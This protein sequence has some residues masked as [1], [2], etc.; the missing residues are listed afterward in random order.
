M[1][2]S[3]T[4]TADPHHTPTFL[5]LRQHRA[6]DTEALNKLFLRHYEAVFRSL[7]VRLHGQPPGC[8]VEDL[9]QDAMLAAIE[10]LEQ[11]EPQQDAAWR[12]WVVTIGWRLFL[13]RVRDANTLKRGAGTRTEPLQTAS[14]S[15]RQL[16]GQASGE[17][18]AVIASE[19]K[20]LMDLC[21]SQ[22]TGSRRVVI[23]ERDYLGRDWPD[24]ARLLNREVGACQ[25]LHL[26][27]RTKLA[28]LMARARAGRTEPPDARAAETPST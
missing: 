14:G 7:R 5:L 26:R 15:W 22:L 11:Y 18:A 20:R 9:V 17:V 19:E 16:P 13:N 23:L 1:T 27:T 2:D 4:S 3:V 8:E 24:I 25:Q 21:V 6:G 12:D 10:G 28:A